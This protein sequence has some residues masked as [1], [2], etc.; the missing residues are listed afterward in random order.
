M[1]KWIKLFKHKNEELKLH[2]AVEINT[3]DLHAVKG[4]IID[5]YS[6]RASSPYVVIFDLPGNPAC[7]LSFERK[8][9]KKV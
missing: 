9:L 4:E 5:I 2:D 6:R 7:L 8:D 1:F 3:K